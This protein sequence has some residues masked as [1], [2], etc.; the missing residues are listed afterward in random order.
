MNR[1]L[2]VL[3]CWACA[4]AVSAQVPDYVPADGL[5]A[6][7][8]FDGNANDESGNGYDFMAGEYTFVEDQFNANS[9]AIAFD[10]LN[11]G[12]VTTIP[13]SFAT[14]EEGTYSFWWRVEGA[15]SYNGYNLLTFP[16][17]SGTLDGNFLAFTLDENWYWLGCEN[18][19]SGFTAT[20]RIGDD[21]HIRALDCATYPE[22]SSWN[23][24]VVTCTANA[25]KLYFNG[26]FIGEEAV[27]VDFGQSSPGT[28]SLGA[29]N[30]P[31]QSS[32]TVRIMDDL[33]IWNRALDETE[34][35]ALYIAE[36]QVEGCTDPTACNYIGSVS[37][38]DNSCT[39]A[40][41][42]QDCNGDCLGNT[43]WYVDG[44]ADPS[45]ATG[46][47]LTPFATLQQALDLACTSDTVLIAPGVY[48]ENASLSAHGVTV[49]GY[50]PSLNPDSVAGNI[51]LDGAELGTTL[52][53]SGENTV[54]EDLTIQ[55]GKSGYGAGLYLSGA[56]GSVARRCIVRD[57]VGT[58][59]ITAHG[60]A[61]NS[62][63]CLIEDCLVTGNYG[64]KHTVNTGGNNNII[65]NCR[66]VEN[67]AWET[68]G[69]IVVY[70]T[71]M[72]IE[73]C[74]ISN[75]NNGG[76]TTY[77]DDT[78]IDHCT[79]T[80]N[81]NFGC[82]IWCYSNDADFYITN[83]IIANNGSTEFSMVQT[84]DYVA[85][86]HLRNCL[87][88]GGIDYD[89]LSVYKQF[90][91]D[92]S[93]I[94][95][96]PVLQSNYELASTSPAIAQGTNQRYAFDGTLTVE[97]SV[98]DLNFDV[99]PA[100]AGTNPDLGCFEHPLGITEPTP[101]CTDTEACN[102]NISATEDDGSCIEP[103]C[104]DTTACNFDAEAT[105]GG[106]MCI[107]SGCTE[108]NA[109]NYNS[110]ALCEGEVCDY[111]CCPGP[112]C[113]QDITVWDVA[114]GQC[115]TTAAADTVVVT[116][117]LMVYIPACGEG[118][119]WNPILQ[120]CIV[121]IPADL[122]FD[123]CITISDLLEFLPAHGFCPP[124][125][126][127]D[128]DE[129]EGEWDCVFDPWNCSDPLEYHGYDYATVQV[130]DQC[131]FAENLRTT[132]Y[133]NGDN[134]PGQLSD[135]DWSGTTSGAQAVFGEGEIQCTTGGG[136][137]Y[138]NLPGFDVCNESTSFQTYGRL[139]NAYAV[140]DSRGIC[141]SGWQVS[142]NESW[143]VLEDYLVSQGF[144]GMESEVLKSSTGWNDGATGTNNY[145]FGALPGGQ[146]TS[147]GFSYAGGFGR[148]FS[149]IATSYTS[150]YRDFWTNGTMPTYVASGNDGLS[151]R[152]VKD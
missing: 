48:V 77:Y 33:G 58:G 54:L 105:C 146:R 69:G 50:A 99:R 63:N 118:T 131:W 61:L 37:E 30:N 78:V 117:T 95:L 8:P 71:N 65:R 84:G 36:L 90:D 66:I 68:G 124:L 28:L 129:I 108:E 24:T 5:V 41:F 81:T 127:F 111:T 9:S 82:F 119:L 23:H 1:I 110:A 149:P 89:W 22:M 115:I 144:A 51:I 132:E 57:N 139:Y 88:E 76:V 4:A 46:D 91:A 42:G 31:A 148:I 35:Q 114:L 152:C 103:T 12:A 130:G 143:N 150:A 134:I 145:G 98:Q 60:I 11:S 121:A 73:N 133:A 25:L 74:L 67:N 16:G 128:G 32:L 17:A 75:N 72:L 34:I 107:P 47:T 45:V 104:D 2:L 113:C 80:D 85:T 83:S 87:V 151:V 52:F 55:N 141:P 19:S 126:V 106:G 135:S 142:S 7:Y 62:S 140:I 18:S 64:R 26:E 120:E 125:P 27:I 20:A 137:G 59:D 93:L 13:N 97:S 96:P 116:D 112:G 101:G 86:V 136:F 123:G 29:H 79:I 56:D 53:I 6:W 122:N 49:K 40:S 44:T 102:Y 138:P 15:F 38:D 43:R 70:S 21:F 147:G 3:L 100:P 92:E 39:Y 109:C 94:T 14:S 10:Q